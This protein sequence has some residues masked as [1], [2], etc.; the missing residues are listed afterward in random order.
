MELRNRL[1]AA[2]GL[3]LRA[4]IVFDYPTPAALAGYLRGELLP[5]EPTV[6]ERMLAELGRMASDLRGMASDACGVT[7]GP[8]DEPLEEQER[9]EIGI[10]LRA[11]L[12]EVEPAAAAARPGDD[13]DSASDDELFELLDDELGIA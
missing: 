1:N 8:R 9:A 2:T 6:V 7:S 4:T 11:L 3:T 12:A 13:L 5:D 10:R